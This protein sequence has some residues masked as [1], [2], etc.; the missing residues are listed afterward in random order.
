MGDPTIR[1]RPK[2][3]VEAVRKV[4]GRMKCRKASSSSG[5][6]AEILQASSEESIGRMTALYNCVIDECEIPDD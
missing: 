1:R 2:L 5:V 4:L 6:V 3:E